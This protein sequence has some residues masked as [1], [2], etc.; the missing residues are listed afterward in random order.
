L[1]DNGYKVTIIDSLINSSKKCFDKIIKITN[2]EKIKLIILDLCDRQK[3]FESLKNI[4]DIDVCIHFAS[5]KAVGESTEKPLTYYHNNLISTINLLDI[6]TLIKVKYFIF[7]S[8]ATVYDPS[9]N[10]LKEENSVGNNITNPYGKTKY[11]IEEIIS[12]YMNSNQAILDKNQHMK[13]VI[14]RYFNPIGAHPSGELGE[15]PN[16]IPNNLLPYIL[17]VMSGK[18]KKLNIYAEP[19]FKTPDGT[20][21]RDYVHVMDVAEGHIASID[22]VEKTTDRVSVFNLGTGKG[23]SVFELVNKMENICQ[24]KIPYQI[25]ERRK[26]DLDQTIADVSKAN[27]LLFFNGKPYKA[28]RDLNQMCKDSYKWIKNN[29]NGFQ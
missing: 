2:N 13:S 8:S 24:C 29:P 15:H 27:N 28:S 19:K 20:G 11:M 17:Q 12:D 22:Y 7:S 10:T 18:L 26:G 3:L 25:T 5:L 23:T 1:L 21:V 14:L 4:N 16:G 6:L 9:N